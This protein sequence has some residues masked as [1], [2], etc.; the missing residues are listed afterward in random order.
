MS[1]RQQAAGLIATCTA[2]LAGPA[3]HTVP[4]ARITAH[5]VRILEAAKAE[6]PK[7]KLLAALEIERAMWPVLLSA[8]HAVL[9]ALPGVEQ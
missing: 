9:Q 5:A 3:A 4:G 1:V 6:A 8:M 7:D 2:V